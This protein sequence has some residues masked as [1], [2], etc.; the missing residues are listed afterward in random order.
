MLTLHSEMQGYIWIPGIFCFS[1]LPID[2]V[3]LF[4]D[5]T[6]RPSEQFTYG[7][8][9]KYEYIFTCTNKRHITVRKTKE[10]QVGMLYLVIRSMR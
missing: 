9:N 7:H 10:E 5:S 2:L 3:P 4:R 1:R 6:T 8:T